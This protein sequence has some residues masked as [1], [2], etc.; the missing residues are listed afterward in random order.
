MEAYKKATMWDCQPGIME[1]YKKATMWDC[2]P[3]V[4]KG[5]GVSP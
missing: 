3:G 5:Q 2:Q 1:A 4:T